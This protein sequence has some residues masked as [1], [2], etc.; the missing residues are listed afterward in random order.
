VT[1]NKQ[2]YIKNVYDALNVSRDMSMYKGENI[3]R[4]MIYWENTLKEL[5]E[6]L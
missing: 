6:L 5:G 3:F 1:D 4:E 2:K